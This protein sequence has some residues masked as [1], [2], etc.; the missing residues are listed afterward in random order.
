L[1]CFQHVDERVLVADHPAMEEGEQ[2][3]GDEDRAEAGKEEWVFHRNLETSMAL[4]DNLFDALTA[5]D[6]FVCGLRVSLRMTSRYD[7]NSSSVNV[8][9][10]TSIKASYVSS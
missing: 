9:S 5:F 1:V 6:L 8:S 7:L 4:P 10:S 3:R 2:E